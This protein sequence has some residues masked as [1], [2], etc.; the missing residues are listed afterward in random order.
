MANNN[1]LT[2]GEAA[3]GA[4]VVD[5]FIRFN[6]GTEQITAYVPTTVDKHYISAYSTALQTNT[7]NGT[8]SIPMIFETTADANSLS[9]VNNTR[10]TPTRSGKYNIQFSVQLDKTDSGSDDVEIWIAVNGTAVPNSNTHLTL[11]T[12]NAKSVAAWNWIVALQ[13]NQYAE[14]YWYSLD[15]AMRLF[16][17]GAQTNPTRPGIPSTI[18][19]AIEI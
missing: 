17:Q 18:V 10:I 8:A 2:K 15:T 5:D 6:D 19:T 9:I 16:A 7:G 4:L 1:R 14:I 13:S 12:N 11:P 3:V